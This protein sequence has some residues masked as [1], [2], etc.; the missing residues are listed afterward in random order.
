VTNLRSR[1]H[2]FAAFN[3][4]IVAWLLMVSCLAYGQSNQSDQN[5]PNREV[6]VTG[7]RTLVARSR[8]PSDVLL[9]SLDTIIHERSVCCGKDSA[10]EDSAQRADPASLKDIAAKLQGRHLLSDGRPIMITAEYL[11]P[12][13]IGPSMLIA[14]LRDKHALLLE[15]NSRFY[16]CYGVT[17][18]EYY[19]ADSGGEV[20]TISTLLLLDTRYADARREAVFSRATDDWSKVQGML[21]VAVAQP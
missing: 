16:V 1:R 18:W 10:L 17:Y 2:P 21:W 5:R 11:E 6:R 4:C 8:E 14:T 7:L 20:D 15:W 9:T 19:D 12:S 3:H 13:A